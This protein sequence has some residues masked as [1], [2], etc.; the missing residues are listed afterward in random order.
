MRVEAFSVLFAVII[1]AS[2]MEGFDSLKSP[3]LTG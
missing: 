1:P 2:E 3:I